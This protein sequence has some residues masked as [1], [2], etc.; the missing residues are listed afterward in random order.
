MYDDVKAHLQ[1]MLDIG[2]IWKLYSLWATT[3]VIVS[4][5]DWSLR[6]CIDLTKLKKMYCQGCL[7]TT[8]H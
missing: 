7:L 5:K 4:E 1:E 3:V 8:L 2:A 6:L